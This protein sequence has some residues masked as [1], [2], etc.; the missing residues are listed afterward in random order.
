MLR[1]LLTVFALDL[2]STGFATMPEVDHEGTRGIHTATL[3]ANRPNALTTSGVCVTVCHSVA[4]EWRPLGPV[5]NVVVHDRTPS[6]PERKNGSP[7]VPLRSYRGAH[8]RRLSLPLRDA[9]TVT[10]CRPPPQ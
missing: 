8:S 7:M 10:M 1:A 5:R 9:L 6:S 3:L 4:Q 2:V